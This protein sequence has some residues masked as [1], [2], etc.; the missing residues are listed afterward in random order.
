[1]LSLEGLPFSEGKQKEWI[2]E[3]GEL[4]GETG[5]RRRRVNNGSDVIYERRMGK[6]KE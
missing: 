2:W 1:L 4:G 5:R 3:R 6:K